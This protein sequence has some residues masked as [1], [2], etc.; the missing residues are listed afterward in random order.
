MDRFSH[1]GAFFDGEEHKEYALDAV[2][3][4]TGYD[5]HSPLLKDIVSFG[6]RE[7]HFYNRMF[8][9][10]MKRHILAIIGLFNGAGCAMPVCEYSSWPCQIFKGE[11]HIP[12]KDV[13]WKRFMPLKNI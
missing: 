6:E 9:P 4:A 2:V 12:S 1:K 3:M 13:M 7:P 8:P 5:F 11:K 10:E